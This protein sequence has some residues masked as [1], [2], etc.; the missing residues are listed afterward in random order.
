MNDQFNE[1]VP[2]ETVNFA[3]KYGAQLLS[4]DAAHILIGSTT[5]NSKD[6]VPFVLYRVS[7]TEITAKIENVKEV[8]PSSREKRQL[9]V[10]SIDTVP[11]KALAAKGIIAYPKQLR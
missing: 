7:D 11:I 2:P 1:A 4:A 8:V 6:F 9:W 3:N 5:P 10:Q